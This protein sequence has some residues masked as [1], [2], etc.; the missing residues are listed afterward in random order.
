[1]LACAS[2][3]K[4]ADVSPSTHQSHSYIR[5]N[6]LYYVHGMQVVSD[7]LTP[8]DGEMLMMRAQNN[9]VTVYS[10]RMSFRRP[11]APSGP[12]PV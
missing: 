2:A 12:T 5:F 7:F 4:H 1:M 8:Y 9:P 6:T 11:A 3:C 10:Y